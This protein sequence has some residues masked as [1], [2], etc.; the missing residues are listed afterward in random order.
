MEV[1]VYGTAAGRRQHNKALEMLATE[2]VDIGCY[3]RVSRKHHPKSA[4][5]LAWTFTS[6]ADVNEKMAGAAGAYLKEQYAEVGIEW[7]DYTHNALRQL[8]NSK[9][10]VTTPE[11][12]KNLKIRVPG[13]DVFM[14]TWNALG[15]DVTSMA[16][17]EVF[18]A[19]QQDH[20]RQEKRRKDLPSSN[21]IQEVNKYGLSGTMP[22]TDIPSYNKALGQPG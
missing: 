18:T 4:S 13:G 17:S 14:D 5:V 16:W 10:P 3:A 12:L 7:V 6:Y 21:S 11:D 15:A 22:M 19:L 1:K 8:S 9:R 20:R 2:E